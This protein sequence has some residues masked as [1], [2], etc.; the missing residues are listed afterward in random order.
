MAPAYTLSQGSWQMKM[1]ITGAPALGLALCLLAGC[2]DRGS[3]G[4]HVSAADAEINAGN[5]LLVAT[6]TISALAKTE[7]IGAVGDLLGGLADRPAGP[8]HASS[9]PSAARLTAPVDDF[10]TAPCQAAQLSGTAPPGDPDLPLIENRLVSGDRFS[11]NLID[12]RLAAEL[13]F[14]G[15]LDVRVDRFV[16]TLSANSVEYLY[17]STLRDLQIDMATESYV[18]NG[19]MQMFFGSTSFPLVFA[20]LS[21]QRLSIAADGESATLRDYELA[22]EGVLLE[23]PDVFGSVDTIFDGILSSSEFAGEVRFQTQVPFR[24]NGQPRAEPSQGQI[25]IFGADG[26]VLRLTVASGEV[27]LDLDADGDGSYEFN[28]ITTWAALT[29]AG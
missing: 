14:S 27:Q 25:R 2:S 13:L 20:A 11:L 9:T 1:K 16:G 19:D 4:S 24:T 12:C 5:A 10:A 17:A 23:K 22:S 15:S 21:G 3:D 6:T 18:A 29:R 26:A 7:Y 8:R 28:A